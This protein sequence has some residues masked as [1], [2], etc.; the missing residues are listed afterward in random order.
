MY[1]GGF[2]VAPLQLKRFVPESGSLEKWR[3]AFLKL[4]ANLPVK[5]VFGLYPGV[6]AGLAKKVVW[7][8]QR[9]RWGCMRGPVLVGMNLGTALG[10][11]VN[12]RLGVHHGRT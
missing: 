11:Q 3:L 7:C 4:V 1:G 10:F 6:R 5:L 9:P 12:G 8:M 2:W